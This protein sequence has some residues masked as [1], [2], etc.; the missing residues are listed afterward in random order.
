MLLGALYG[1]PAQEALVYFQALHDMREE[2]RFVAESYETR[3]D[4]SA[5]VALRQVQREQVL[6][7]LGPAGE[8]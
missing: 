4:G 7:L 5:C 1:L 6:R 2:P 3:A 8:E